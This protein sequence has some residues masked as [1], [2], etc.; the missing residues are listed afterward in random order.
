MKSKKITEKSMISQI[1]D[2]Y[3]ELAEVLMTDYGFHCIGCQFAAIETIEDGALSH[4]MKKREIKEMVDN[5][6]EL[7]LKGFDNKS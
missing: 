5:L 4:G 3:P 7:I 1:I 6:N 2:Q